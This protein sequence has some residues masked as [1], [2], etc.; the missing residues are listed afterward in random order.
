MIH[1]MDFALDH[2]RDALQRPASCAKTGPFC[3]SFQQAE[4]G[5][6]LGVRQLGRASRGLAAPPASPSALSQ[7]LRP[8]ADRRAAH[9]QEAG[10]LRLRLASLAEQ[11][12]ACQS[13]LLHLRTGQSTWFP[14]PA[15]IVRQFI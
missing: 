12:A 9:T 14:F 10:D 1:D 8:C 13:P 6:T 3:I 7:L 2:F 4:Q 15:R 11:T 5:L